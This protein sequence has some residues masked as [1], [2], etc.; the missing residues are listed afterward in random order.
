MNKV[1]Y[2]QTIVGLTHEVDP[3]PL[4]AEPLSSLTVRELLPEEE[5]GI[6]KQ[7]L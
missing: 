7:V 3:N 2:I 6:E 5:D 1:G 4:Q